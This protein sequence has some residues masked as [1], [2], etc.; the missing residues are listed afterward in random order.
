MSFT[1]DK[2]LHYAQVELSETDGTKYGRWYKG[3]N[4]APGFDAPGTPWCAMFAS[5]VY[6]MAGDDRYPAFAYCPYWINW[7]KE[8]GYWKTNNPEPGDLVFFDWEKDAKCDHVAIVESMN[9]NGT[10]NVIEGNSVQG[11][12]KRTTYNLNVIIGYSNT[13]AMYFGE[14]VQETPAPIPQP[15][16]PQNGLV[17]PNIPSDFISEYGK[18][19]CTEAEGI[20]IL[21]APSLSG[22]KTGLFYNYGEYV[23]YEGYVKREGYVWITWISTSGERRW[24]AVRELPSMYAYG[25]FE[26][27][28][29]CQQR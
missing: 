7:L 19:T 3:V 23:F 13:A 28:W 2:V 6:S 1:R 14:P 29:A 27:N 12:V 5:Y 4:N 11:N 10:I 20:H 24:M 25:T 18:F 17:E 26:Q 21:K 9:S 8:N 15:E 22:E 16:Q